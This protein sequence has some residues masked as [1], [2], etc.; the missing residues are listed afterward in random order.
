[1]IEKSKKLG[2]FSEGQYNV[3]NVATEKTSFGWKL[4]DTKPYVSGR[5]KGTELF[6]E[7]DT[8]MKNYEELNKLEKELEEKNRQISN[9]KYMVGKNDK[10]ISTSVNVLG[11]VLNGLCSFILI[12]GLIFLIGGDATGI[13]A[14]LLSIG[15]IGFGIYRKNIKANAFRQ[16][17]EESKEIMNQGMKLL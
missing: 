15:I 1:M 14:V 13:V 5:T 6:F 3:E 9:C 17:I 10:I 7:R 8:E 16:L 11:I 12:I 4:V 2:H